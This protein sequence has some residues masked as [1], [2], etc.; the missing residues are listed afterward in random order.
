M[1]LSAGPGRDRREFI[2]PAKLRREGRAAFGLSWESKL[3][4][5]KPAHVEIRVDAIRGFAIRSVAI[6]V[7]GVPVIAVNVI[8]INVIAIVISIVIAINVKI[9]L[10]QI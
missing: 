10:F 9:G 6:G 3:F 7:I 2:S 1:L 5:A 4:E 8:E